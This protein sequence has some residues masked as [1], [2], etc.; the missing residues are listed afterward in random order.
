M[1]ATVAEDV[2]PLLI[3][4]AHDHVPV[5]HHPRAPERD[6]THLNQVHRPVAERRHLDL[7]AG[8][9]AIQFAQNMTARVRPQAS[10]RDEF[11]LAKATAARA[12]YRFWVPRA[13]RARR[14]VR[15]DTTVAC[16]LLQEWCDQQ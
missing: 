1:L 15:L 9:A 10:T 13:V 11:Q 3:D 4:A 5:R 2:A 7:G 14:R 8:A 16:A 6:W 12:A